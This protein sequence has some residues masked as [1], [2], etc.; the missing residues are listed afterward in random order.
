M[1][2]LHCSEGLV[3]GPGDMLWRRNS[4][5]TLGGNLA[6]TQP[7]Y[8]VSPKKKNVQDGC[9]L[10]SGMKE[11]ETDLEEVS[12]VVWIW[13]ECVTQ[14]LCARS[15]IPYVGTPRR[16][17]VHGSTS[18]RTLALKMLR[19][20]KKS[21]EGL[22]LPFSPQ[23]F[24]FMCFCFHDTTCHDALSRYKQMWM[25]CSSVSIDGN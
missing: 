11:R 24:F 18:L 25:P 22:W 5:C 21:S 23:A 20:C 13:L 1:C 19:C 9:S 14:G 17:R 15:F 12:S 7:L 2:G 3:R 4:N 8:F 16:G 6:Q 10:E